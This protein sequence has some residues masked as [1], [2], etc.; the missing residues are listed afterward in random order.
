MIGGSIIDDD[1]IVKQKS[2][3]FGYV[4][5]VTLITDD[6]HAALDPPLGLVQRDNI[7]ATIIKRSCTYLW[8]EMSHGG[9]KQSLCYVIV[10][11]KALQ[12]HNVTIDT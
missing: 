1:A 4:D 10:F 7:D 12:K 11:R 8:H 2:R 3:P 9:P 5:D 6:S